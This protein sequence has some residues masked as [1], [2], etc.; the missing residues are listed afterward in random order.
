MVREHAGIATNQPISIRVAGD[1]NNPFVDIV[2]FG[3]ENPCVT[4]PAGR[5]YNI[6]QALG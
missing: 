5:V 2:P 4:K 3:Y 1:T 6:Y